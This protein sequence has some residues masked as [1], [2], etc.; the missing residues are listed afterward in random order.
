MPLGIC[1][2]SWFP[3]RPLRAQSTSPSVW[4]APLSLPARRAA[5]ANAQP[6][7]VAQQLNGGQNRAD[8]AVVRQVA[9]GHRRAFK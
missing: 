5:C 6:L 3:S 4:H 1:P 9:A 8:Q 7:E 2:E